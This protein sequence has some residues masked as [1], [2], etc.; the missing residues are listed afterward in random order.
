L[1]S[2]LFLSLSASIGSVFLDDE[3]KDTG[4]ESFAMA[5]H[6]GEE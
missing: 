4:D 1:L 6:E 2:W 3:K 5:E